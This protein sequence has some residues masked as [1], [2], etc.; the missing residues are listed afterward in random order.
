MMS[1]IERLTIDSG[2]A[3]VNWTKGKQLF[4]VF[5]FRPLFGQSRRFDRGLPVPV[6]PL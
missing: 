2:P 4:F 5:L 1:V 3:Q 6:C